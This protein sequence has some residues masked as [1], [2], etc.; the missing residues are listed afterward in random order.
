[1]RPTRTLDAR[2]PL[3][4]RC[5]RNLDT[6]RSAHAAQSLRCTL[7]GDRVRIERFVDT[8][9]ILGETPVWSAAEHALYWVDVRRPAL[10]RVDAGSGRITTWKMPELVGSAALC[11][12]GG[13]L[14][15]L[16]SSVQR[17]D[18]ATE[19]MTLVAAPEGGNGQMRLNDGRCDRRGRFWVG[20]MNDV[21]RGPEGR[22]YRVDGRGGCTSFVDGVIVP[23]SLSWSPD[24]RTMY[25]TG[26]DLRTMLAYRF[27]VDAGTARDPRPFAEVAA[28]AVPDGAT[29]DAD[30]CVWCALYDGWRI[31]RYTPDGRVDRVVDVPVQ[32][33]TSL[34]F[35]GPGLRTLFVTTAR[36]RIAPDSLARQPLAG[37]VL[38]LDVGVGGLPEPLFDA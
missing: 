22:L 37:S 27:D 12:G 26:P 14:V 24:D 13:V 17:F 4:Q 2:V 25:F 21:T 7:L 29:V 36:Q 3:R 9:D 19:R 11:R 38:A 1:M 10:H 8:E 31:V 33:P 18:P 5:V 23:N 32:S 30:G 35:G 28:P 20:S 15:A 6:A 34:T 16:R